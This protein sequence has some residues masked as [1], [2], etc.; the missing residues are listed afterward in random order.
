QM[1]EQEMNQ[2]I[3][4]ENNQNQPNKKPEKQNVK[5]QQKPN[6]WKGFL[7]MIAAALFGSVI[8]LAAVTQLDYFSPVN[9]NTNVDNVNSKSEQVQ[10]DDNNIANHVINIIST[11]DL[12]VN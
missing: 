1:N 12:D 2:A 11:D 5:K 7:G 9:I 3:N 10:Y 6:K 8:T 4:P